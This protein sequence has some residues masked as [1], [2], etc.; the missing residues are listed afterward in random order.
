MYGFK[1]AKTRV[2][3]C[4]ASRP[5]AGDGSEISYQCHKIKLQFHHDQFLVSFVIINLHNIQSVLTG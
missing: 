1:V 2:G 3:K 5:S 4:C